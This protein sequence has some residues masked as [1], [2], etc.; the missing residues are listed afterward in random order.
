MVDR[1]GLLTPRLALAGARED[2]QAVDALRDLRVGLNMTML[3]SVRAAPGRAALGRAD[4]AVATLM[5]G[6]AR[7]FAQLPSVDEKAEAQL[8][9]SLDNALRAVCHGGRDAAQ[10]EA[11]AAL[12]GM[13]R[14]LF[15]QAPGYLPSTSLVP[16]ETR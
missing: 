4:A 11:L 15:P 7:R 1:V 10:R 13:R 16:E 2:L 3:Q 9:D 8:L 14:D 6:L 5:H 12:A